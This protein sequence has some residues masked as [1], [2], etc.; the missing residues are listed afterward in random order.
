MPDDKRLKGVPRI[1]S[2][3]ER[4]GF[5]VPQHEKQKAREYNQ[6]I[7]D[8]IAEIIANPNDPTKTLKA[9]E[10]L[11]GIKGKLPEAEST[12]V[13]FLVGQHLTNAIKPQVDSG[14][15]DQ[16]NLLKKHL[17]VDAVFGAAQA[18]VGLFQ[19]IDGIAK[20][21]KLS[22]PKI[23]EKMQ[24]NPQLQSQLTKAIYKSGEGVDPKMKSYYESKIA[25]ANELDNHRAKSS[26][27]IG[28][29][30]GNIQGNAIRRTKALKELALE[31]DQ[32]QRQNR[33]EVRSLLGDKRA[34]DQMIQNDAYRNFGVKEGRFNRSLNAMNAQVGNG[35]ENIFNGGYS[36][37]N[38]AIDVKAIGDQL[39]TGGSVNP[40]SESMSIAPRNPADFNRVQ[41]E[42]QPVQSISPQQSGSSMSSLDPN[43][44]VPSVP[45]GLRPEIKPIPQ[46]RAFTFQDLG[47]LMSDSKEARTPDRVARFA[48]FINN[49]GSQAWVDPND[50]W[51]PNHSTL[52]S[53]VERQVNAFTPAGQSIDDYDPR[54]RLASKFAEYPEHQG[55]SSLGRKF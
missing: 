2:G 20:K 34:E 37:A 21:N 18:G 43:A 44:V 10:T 5:N 28:Q 27:N 25:E 32:V 17:T 30:T 24:A 6:E 16:M 31:D 50:E 12:N 47:V 19:V 29:Y 36:A 52:L 26:G 14:A 51:T 3:P 46:S 35:L 54:L 45:N 49:S 33:Q 1:A 13:D 39:D 40:T 53:N 41:P 22:P 7:V 23:P 42:Q 11:N 55:F 38:A 15:A 9:Y 48:D 4:F 8:A